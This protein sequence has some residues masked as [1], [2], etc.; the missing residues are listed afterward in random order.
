MAISSLQNMSVT[1]NGT[2][3]S[4]LM[5][6]LAFRYQAYFLNFG[7]S[8]LSPGSN[9]EVTRQVIKF[10]RPS[11]SFDEIK[12]PVYNSTVKIIGKHTWKDLTCEIR[13][14]AKG[15]VSTRIGNQLQTQLDFQEQSSASAANSYKFTVILDISDGGNGGKLYT[16]NRILE[17]WVILGCYLKEVNYNAQG[18]DYATS[19]A[20]KIGMTITFDN[21]YQDIGGS[22][23]NSSVFAPTHSS[24]DLATSPAPL[25]VSGLIA[26]EIASLQQTGP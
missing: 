16:T 10:D 13:D 20:L 6:K 12:L 22:V 23:G 21:A 25:S 8:G 15:S 14:D 24:N 9:L 4:L 19:E 11:V 18:L 3:T 2:N 7:S 5:P 1:A 26:A 17:R